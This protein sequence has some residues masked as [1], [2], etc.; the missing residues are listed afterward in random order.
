MHRFR[1]RG[2]PESVLPGGYDSLIR[3]RWTLVLVVFTLAACGDDDRPLPDAC[4]AEPATISS[5]LRSAPS[6][7]RVHGARLSTCVREASDADELQGVGASLVGAAG[8]LADS[9]GADP[10]GQAELSLGY[11]VG[12]ARR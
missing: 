4:T 11:L 1:P 10:G 2:G 9:A 8:R 7:V 3:R 5:A 12:A 6:P